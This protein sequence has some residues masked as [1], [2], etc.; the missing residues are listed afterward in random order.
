M[1]NRLLRLAIFGVLSSVPL[2]AQSASPSAAMGLE[3]E[4]K[5]GEAAEVW[6][7]VTARNPGDAAAFAALGVDL[8][9]LGKYEEAAAAY[10]RALK[11]NP[12]LP[13]I[14]LNLGLAEFKQ[15][16]WSA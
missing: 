11:L 8:A 2:L 4:Q 15:E 13:G 7:A 9:R 14:Q 5:W 6:K 10:R 3:Q 1:F 16:H 12:K